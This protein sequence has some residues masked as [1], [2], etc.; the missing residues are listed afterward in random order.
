MFS[1]TEQEFRHQEVIVAFTRQPTGF[2]IWQ[3]ALSVISGMAD[4][5]VLDRLRP[6][7]VLFT[8][9]PG[10][11]LN[12]RKHSWLAFLIFLVFKL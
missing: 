7:G 8:D 11:G 3:I 6:Y 4:V 10:G 5:A 1:P 2:A 12:N 9:I